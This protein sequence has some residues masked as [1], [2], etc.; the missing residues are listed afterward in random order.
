MNRSILSIFCLFLFCQVYAAG[1]LK[2]EDSYSV[3]ELDAERSTGLNKIF[4]IRQPGKYT[5]SFLSDNTSD[6]PKWYR[7]SNLGGG[8]AEEITD[9][10]YDGN[11]SSCSSLDG[12]MG[13]IIENGDTRYYYWIVDYSR[14]VFSING[15]DIADEADCNSNTLNVSGEAQPIHYYSING[16]Q[17]TLSRG[18]KVSYN[19]LEWDDETK[20]Y[21]QLEAVKT[22]DSFDKTIVITPP[23]YCN[24][25][26]TVYGDRFLEQWNNPVSLSS[27]NVMCKAVDCRTSAEQSDKEA[28]NSNQI[29]SGT[30]GLGGSAPAEIDFLAFTTDAVIHNEWQIARD[31]DFEDIIYRFNQ[32]DLNHSF[33]EEGTFYVRFIGSNSDG[34]CETFSETYTVEIGNSELKCPN[35]F[36]PGAS[37]G[38]NDEWKVAYRSLIEFECWIFD[39]YGTEMFHFNDPSKGWDGK[40]KGKLVKPGVYF[41]VIKAKGADGKKYKKSGDINIIRFKGHQGTG[42]QTAG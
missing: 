16:R 40:Y 19:T 15:I 25:E 6:R 20:N 35:A 2:F 27:P 18:I 21:K 4:V 42:T 3:I 32:Q 22:I 30:S 9:V 41:Y 34:S 37:E 29:S 8:F 24:T 39:R 28:E 17:N 12:D 33:R 11:R 7:Y 31:M 10:S 13:Y 36:S 38:V 1:P 23:A 26:F 14:H 5:A